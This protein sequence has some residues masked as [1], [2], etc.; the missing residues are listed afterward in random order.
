MNDE[1]NQ[2]RDE[3]DQNMPDFLD[4]TPLSWENGGSPQPAASRP[5]TPALHTS[6]KP[7]LFSRFFAII[8]TKAFLLAGSALACISAFLEINFFG[9]VLGFALTVALVLALETMKVASIFYRLDGE[10]TTL[11]T[12]VT[13]GLFLLSAFATVGLIGG[14]LIA[15]HAEEL[16]KGQL[17]NVEADYD[18]RIDELEASYTPMIAYYQDVMDAERVTGPKERYHAAEDGMEATRREMMAKREALEAERAGA[19]QSVRERTF[20]DVTLAEDRH[21]GALTRLLNF[22]HIPISYTGCVFFLSV[23]ISFLIEAGIYSVF[24]KLREQYRGA[25]RMAMKA[26]DYVETARQQA[27][28]Q[29]VKHETWRNRF[30]QM[31]RHVEKS[32]AGL[33]GGPPPSSNGQA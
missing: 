3:N 4:D 18:E 10:R 1:Q 12:S 6:L 14:G 26:E 17:E 2:N 19:L 33:M 20:E 21:V 30:Q 7:S 13:I 5:G 29:K 9:G 24:N 25:L 28:V 27:R 11:D 8:V 23:L 22:V 15:P 32:L 31:V 16:R